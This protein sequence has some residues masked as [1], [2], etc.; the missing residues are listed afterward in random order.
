MKL[1]ASFSKVKYVDVAP[2]VWLDPSVDGRDIQKLEIFRSRLP[3][4][5][6][7][8]IFTDVDEA[9]LQYGRMEY[10]G[11]EEARSRYIASV[12]SPSY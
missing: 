5:L 7:Q 2:Y 11:N 6:F 8:K 1:P 3:M 10:H 12:S 9:T 4:Y